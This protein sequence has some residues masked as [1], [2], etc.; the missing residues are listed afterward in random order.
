MKPK[1]KD[2]VEANCIHCEFS[3][4]L[5]NHMV[6]CKFIKHKRSTGERICKTYQTNQ[7]KYNEWFDELSNSF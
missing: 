1:N 4:N 5:N 2:P 6:D 7:K 3:S